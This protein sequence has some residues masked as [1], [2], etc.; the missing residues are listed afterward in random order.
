MLLPAVQ[1]DWLSFRAILL[2]S[3][4]TVI[5]E[6]DLNLKERNNL[7]DQDLD[8]NNILESIKEQGLMIQNGWLRIRYSRK[9]LW[10]QKWE[11][12]F[13]WSWEMVLPHNIPKRAL[14]HEMKWVARCGLE[15]VHPKWNQAHYSF[16]IIIIRLL[17]D[18][19]YYKS[20]TV[21]N[22]C[23]HTWR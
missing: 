22:M 1:D 17:R 18:G 15:A 12:W 14:L 10:T 3:S 5:S 20:N 16:A 6:L 8:G 11:F 19:C 21:H 4:M 7:V 23:L 9:F 13:H 2:L